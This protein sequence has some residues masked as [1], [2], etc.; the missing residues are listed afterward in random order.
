MYQTLTYELLMFYRF[1][2]LGRIPFNFFLLFLLIYSLFLLIY[3]YQ[4]S[5]SLVKEFQKV[6]VIQHFQK[7]IRQLPRINQFLSSAQ[8]KLLLL[9]ITIKQF[10]H[11]FLMSSY[12]FLMLYSLQIQHSTPSAWMNNGLKIRI[13]NGLKIRIRM[14]PG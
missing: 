9:L 11:H 5:L 10:Q 6:I 14:D 12:H 8:Q 4:S 1:S 13:N 2:M 3:S 7:V